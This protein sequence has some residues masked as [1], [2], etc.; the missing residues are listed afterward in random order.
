MRT[1]GAISYTIL[2]HLYHLCYAWYLR[3]ANSWSPWC[4]ST[5]SMLHFVCCGLE[6]L[7]LARFLCGVSSG[8]V[9]SKHNLIR[10]IPDLWEIRSL[11]RG[12]GRVGP[13]PV[14]C[15]KL[16]IPRMSVAGGLPK[17]CVSEST[18]GCQRWAMRT[19]RAISRF[20]MLFYTCEVAPCKLLSSM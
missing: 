8:G 15:C 6:V 12:T 16:M 13:V 19:R 20:A 18:S 7:M 17:S 2:F 5:T 1:S 14:C 11:R 10:S 4:N 3:H 9:L